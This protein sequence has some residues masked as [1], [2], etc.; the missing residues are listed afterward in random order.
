M[1]Y[2]Y[3][4]ISRVLALQIAHP[5]SISS[6]ETLVNNSVALDHSDIW[7]GPT[8]GNRVTFEYLKELQFSIRELAG[9]YGY[10]ITLSNSINEF[11]KRCAS[12]IYENMQTHPS[13]A[14][15]LEI[16]MYM[17]TILLPDVVRWR[18]TS[19]DGTTSVERYI[20]SS[21]GL[22]RNMF[23]RLWWRAHLFYYP[24]NPE[25]PFILL[26]A[27]TEDEQAQITERPSLSGSPKLT[28]EIAIAY[29][30]VMQIIERK[31]INITRRNVLREALKRIS[32]LMPLTML[33][34]LDEQES[35]PVF[36]EVFEQATNIFL[37]QDH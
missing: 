35:Q 29:L 30:K 8:G 31:H 34:M 20:G 19:A 36:D 16:W 28:K 6:I 7:F 24:Q 3:P 37:H 22:R 13:E 10:P 5:A 33:D 27:L 23:G 4:R 14:S 25:D 12:F 9:E 26:S 32:R 18:Y 17:T 15:N 11:D 2:L 21:R 1:Y